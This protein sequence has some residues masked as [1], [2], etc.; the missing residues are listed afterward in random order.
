MTKRTAIAWKAAG[1]RCLERQF[2]ANSAR[3]GTPVAE[4]AGA[5]PGVHTQVPSAAES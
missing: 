4:A 5:L 1:A 2:L 3:T